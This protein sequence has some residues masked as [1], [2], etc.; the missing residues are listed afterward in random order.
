M[1]RVELS[2]PQFGFIVATRVALGAGIGLL[3][4]SLLATRRRK[5]LG[6]ALVAIGAL[7]T[8]PALYLVFRKNGQRAEAGSGLPAS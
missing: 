3:A 2:G 8:A 5:R 7:T 4:S 1:K 6:A